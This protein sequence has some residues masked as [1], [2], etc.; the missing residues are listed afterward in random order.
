MKTF[1]LALIVLIVLFPLNITNELRVSSSDG[2]SNYSINQSITY[3]VEINFSLTHQSGPAGDYAFK[4]SRL[5]DRQPNSTLTL[6]SGPYQESKLLYSSIIGSDPDPFIYRDR[7]NN[8]YDVFNAS[9]LS[10][11]DTITL[12]QL[13]EIT[14]N[15]VS[16]NDINPSEIGEYDTSDEMFSLYC[17]NS[18]LYYERDDININDTSYS[19]VNPSDNPVVKAQKINEWVVDHLVYSVILPNGTQEMG[20]KWAYDNQ[21]GDCSEYSSLMITLLRC[22]GI[23]ARKV[24]GFVITNNTS[25]VPQ[26]GQEWSYFFRPNGQTNLLGHAWVEYYVPNIGWIACDPTW[27]EVGD[28]FN[29]IDYFHLNLNVGAWFSVPEFP[30]ESEFSSPCIISMLYPSSTF[31]FEYGMNIKVISG[32]INMTEIIVII[33]VV[34]IVGVVIIG[35]TLLIRSSRKKRKLNEQASSYY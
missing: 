24:T 21:L 33:V 23:P 10:S 6:Y 17:N 13:Y 3:Q 14:L 7:F 1:K 29:Y 35:V 8:T 2:V 22:Q 27:D 34:S 9:S 25:I 32:G 31:T 4:F 5:N 28:Y 19:I 16:F 20:A 26:V 18:E 11:N 30:D 15:E 12:N